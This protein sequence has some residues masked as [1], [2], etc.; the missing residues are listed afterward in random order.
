MSSLRVIKIHE[1]TYIRRITVDPNTATLAGLEKI[2]FEVAGLSRAGLRVELKYSKKTDI[3]VI[4]SDEELKLLFKTIPEDST[5]RLYA[6]FQWQCPRCTYANSLQTSRCLICQAPSPY[7]SDKKK[8]VPLETKA[9]EE[10]RLRKEAEEKAKKAEEERKK[11]E[12]EEKAQREKEELKKKE[13]EEQ[14][15]KQREEA[16][17]ERKRQ[18]DEEREKKKRRM[19]EWREKRLRRSERRWKRRSAS[20]GEKKKQTNWK[21]RNKREKQRERKKKQKRWSEKERKKRWSEKGRKKN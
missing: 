15:R 3:V 21:E 5:I 1:R 19:K 4:G 17:K 7:P 2:V 11:K 16:E 13:Q 20:S 18:E 9:A 6:D 8:N 10:A 14:D 12:E